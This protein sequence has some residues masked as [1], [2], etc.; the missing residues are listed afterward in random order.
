[1]RFELD[2]TI[3]RSPLQYFQIIS[4]Q[5]YAHQSHGEGEQQ[6]IVPA[7][8]PTKLTH[9]FLFFTS[10]FKKFTLRREHPVL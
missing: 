1:M 8:M 2:F 3:F 9:A 4:V 5:R 10:V 7:E 6:D